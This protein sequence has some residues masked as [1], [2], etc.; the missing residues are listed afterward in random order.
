MMM[1]ITV[2]LPMILREYAGGAKKVNIAS[3]D[4]AVAEI[5]DAL[6]GN[7]PGTGSPPC[8]TAAG[9]GCIASPTS[10]PP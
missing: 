8:W 1:D 4:A 9:C 10:P 6:E 2:H 3:A 7:Y 5:L